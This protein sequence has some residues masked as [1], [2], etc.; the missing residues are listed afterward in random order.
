MRPYKNMKREDRDKVIKEMLDT[1]RT[2]RQNL[3]PKVLQKASG[4]LQTPKQENGE[5]KIDRQKNVA[6]VTRFL[7]SPEGAHLKGKI[8]P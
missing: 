2:I 1:V 6:F 5:I 4:A 8:I 3:D 7:N